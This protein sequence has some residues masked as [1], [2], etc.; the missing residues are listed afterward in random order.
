MPPEFKNI[1][2]RLGVPVLPQGGV[3]LSYR[4]KLQRVVLVAP[5]ENTAVGNADECIFRLGMFEM[6]F[7]FQSSEIK[8]LQHIGSTFLFLLYHDC[9]LFS[10][11]KAV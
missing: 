10:R 9:V 5:D 2:I 3:D 4:G 1:A 11:K 8:I 6:K 7:I